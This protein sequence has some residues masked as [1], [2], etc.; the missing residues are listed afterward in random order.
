MTSTTSTWRGIGGLSPVRAL[1]DRRIFLAA[2]IVVTVAFMSQLSPFFFTVANLTD[3]TQFAVVIGLLA[4][5]QTLVILGGGGGIDLSVGS[6][7]G[8]VGVAMGMFVAAGMNVWLGAAAAI[9]VGG[10]LGFI[11]AALITWLRIPPL[12]ATLGTLYAY[13]A[14]A[15]LLTDGTTIKPFEPDSFF[16]FLG[17]GSIAGFPT[18]VVLVLI[19]AFLIVG[20][21]VTQTK[22]G[23]WLYA[24]GDSAVAAF[25]SGIP[26][27]R[28]RMSLYVVSGVLAGLGA[29]V[30]NSWLLSARP[31]A[32]RVFELQAIAIAVLGGTVITGGSGTI[33]GTLLAVI[34][35]VALN[36][37][38]GL[39]GVAQVWQQGTLG[40]L[41]VVAVILNSY[42]QRRQTT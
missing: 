27:E 12:L 26:V 14:G 35:V 16:A 28:V 18:Q 22:Y 24:V 2:L 41:L 42:L 21:F 39:A 30:T 9:A 8:L 20:F 17:Q 37:G 34:F 11:N 23:K 6:M 33:S 7:L 36:S 19:P 29:V 31:G 4:L 1:T 32:G 5:G 13:R 25:R 10:G 15:L 3:L 38:L 40:L